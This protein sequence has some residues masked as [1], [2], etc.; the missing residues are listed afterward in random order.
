VIEGLA[1]PADGLVD[2]TP[3][4]T[5]APRPKADILFGDLHVRFVPP[6]ADML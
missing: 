1:R 3:C 4:D 5:S 6:R 2:W